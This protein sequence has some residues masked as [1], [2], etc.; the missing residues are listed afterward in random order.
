MRDFLKLTCGLLAVVL[1]ASAQAAETGP[2]PS[3][4]PADAPVQIVEFSE[5]ECAQCA[6]MYSTLRRIRE[7]YPEEVAL[8]FRQLPLNSVHPR[9]QKAAEASLCALEQGRFWEYHDVLF[10]DPGDLAIHTLKD[11]AVR[12]G[13]DAASFDTCLDT[14]AKA[15]AVAT[16][17]RAAIDAGAYSTP[18]LYINGH[19]LT[20]NWGYRDVSRIIDSE[21]FRILGD[22]IRS[23]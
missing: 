16:D 6:D 7:D 17:L 18:T 19:M 23:D 3:Q 10:E 11:R 22:N 13:L 14:G 9:S 8:V 20:G 4:G 21:L 2:H 1:G 15:A 12:I 5:F